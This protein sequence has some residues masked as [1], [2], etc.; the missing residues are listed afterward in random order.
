MTQ[1]KKADVAKRDADIFK[2]KSLDTVYSSNNFY[3]IHTEN[4]STTLIYIIIPH[5]AFK[6]RQYILDRHIVNDFLTTVRHP[7]WTV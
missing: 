2:I 6:H 4:S 7:K 1:V 3:L 5:I